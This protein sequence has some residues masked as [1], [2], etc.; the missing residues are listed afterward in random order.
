MGLFDILAAAQLGKVVEEHPFLTLAG[1]NS[2]SK[3]E[4]EE[5]IESIDDF[6]DELEFEDSITKNNKNKI[7]AL[8][9][10]AKKE[11]SNTRRNK[12]LKDIDKILNS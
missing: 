4:Q 10:Q 2:A 9:N 12:I 8:C 6:I 5:F 1:L 11:K 7:I 3:L